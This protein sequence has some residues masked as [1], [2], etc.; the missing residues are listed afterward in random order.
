VFF[1]LVGL[2]LEMELCEGLI[3]VGFGWLLARLLAGMNGMDN[4]GVH[5]FLHLF[6]CEI[7]KTHFYLD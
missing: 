7:V 2:G 1:D 5:V 3:V 6:R 4:V